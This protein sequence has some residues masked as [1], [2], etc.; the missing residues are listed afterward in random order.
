MLEPI[1]NV[2][3]M[4]CRQFSTSLKTTGKGLFT[5][6]TTCKNHRSFLNP[7]QMSILFDIKKNPKFFKK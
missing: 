7:E 6:K 2:W 3:F 5:F 4:L 1:K